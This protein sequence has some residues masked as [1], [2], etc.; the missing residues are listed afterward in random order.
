MYLMKYIVIFSA[1]L[2]FKETRSCLYQD[3]NQNFFH[4]FKYHTYIRW[5]DG[6]K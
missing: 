6:G 2:I 4:T 5:G 1:L 3:F